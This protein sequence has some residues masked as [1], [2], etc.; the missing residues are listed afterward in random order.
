M[1]ETGLCKDGDQGAHDR[2]G[3]HQIGGSLPV[4]TD[5]GLLGNGEPTRSLRTAV[6]DPRDCAATATA[7]ARQVPNSP[8]VGPGYTPLTV[9]RV[10]PP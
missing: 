6:A 10:C 9:R 5:G 1:A 8:R 4:N 7:G 3:R 2:R